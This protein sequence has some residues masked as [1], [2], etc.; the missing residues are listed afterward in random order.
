MKI[1]PPRLQRVA[2]AHPNRVKDANAAISP[3][4][5][6]LANATHRATVSGARRSDQKNARRRNDPN[7]GLGK[8]ALQ[9]N[10]PGGT[11]IAADWNEVD[12]KTR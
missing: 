10:L 6:S 3:H 1:A 7:A 8:S 12:R 11:T 2:V 5:V 9:A 4:G